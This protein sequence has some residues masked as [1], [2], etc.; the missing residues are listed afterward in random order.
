MGLPPWPLRNLRLAAVE[1]GRPYGTA[2]DGFPGF[3]PAT[4]SRKDRVP[5]TP[6]GGYFRFFPSGRTAGVLD[7]LR[8][9]GE[10]RLTRIGDVR[11]N[12]MEAERRIGSGR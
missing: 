9:N 12:L 7:W 10:G 5:G 6:A 1:P 3:H 2:W 4:P 8:S 11:I